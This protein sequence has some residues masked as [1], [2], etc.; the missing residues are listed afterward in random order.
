MAFSIISQI[1]K[2]KI[3]DWTLVNELSFSFIGKQA[4]REVI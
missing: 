2:R 3:M 4:V 1:S